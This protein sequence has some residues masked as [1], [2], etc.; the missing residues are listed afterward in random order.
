LVDE[1]IVN[2][3]CNANALLSGCGEM[4]ACL[5]FFANKVT[6]YRNPT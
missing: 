4:A 5:R 6:V 3:F 2:L 1:F